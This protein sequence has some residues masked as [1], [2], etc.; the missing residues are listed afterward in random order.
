[1]AHPPGKKSKEEAEKAAVEEEALAKVVVE[2]E[3]GRG[4]RSASLNEDE[5]AVLR[6][7]GLLTLKPLIYA[8][9]VGEDDLGN[10]GANNVHVQVRR[11]AVCCKGRHALCCVCHVLCVLCAVCALCAACR[12]LG[13]CLGA[14]PPP[15][16]CG[17]RGLSTGRPR[18]RAVA[19]RRA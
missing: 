6:G 19:R 4:A 17:W 12:V 15:P 7:L 14:L 1:M 9:N 13:S 18:V 16:R 10:H 11:F 5:A 8:A 3:A 2:L